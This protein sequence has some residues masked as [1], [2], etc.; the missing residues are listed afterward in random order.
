NLEML[1]RKMVSLNRRVLRLLSLTLAVLA[2][3]TLINQG[4]RMDLRTDVLQSKCILQNNPD[5]GILKIN[6]KAFFENHKKKKVTLLATSLKYFSNEN[7]TSALNIPNEIYETERYSM[8]SGNPCNTFPAISDINFDNIYWQK[9]VFSDGKLLYMY[10]AYYDNREMFGNASFVRLNGLMNTK[11]K[12]NPFMCKL[13]FETNNEK[14]VLSDMY[15]EEIWDSSPGQRVWG[16]IIATCK[17]PPEKY[18]EVPFAVSV[19]ERKCEEKPT[20][21]LRVDYNQP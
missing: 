13:W 16:T 11:T 21:V 2:L 1:I 6:S 19:V 10:S 14:V 4:Y 17:I 8:D 20:N 18:G 5:D 9:Y 3:V 7:R 15:Y 12:T